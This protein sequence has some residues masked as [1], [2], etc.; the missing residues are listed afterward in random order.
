VSIRPTGSVVAAVEVGDVGHVPHVYVPPPWTDESIALSDTV[1]RHLRKVMRLDDGSPI[2]YTD[3]R[4]RIGSGTF[5]GEEVTRGAEDIVASVRPSIVLAVAP[6]QATDRAR[7]VVEKAAEL[8]VSELRWLT[9]RFSGPRFPRREKAEAW[10]IGAL[11]QSRGAHLMRIGT[12]LDVAEYQTLGVDLALVADAAAPGIL[13]AVAHLDPETVAIAIGPEG[14]FG[15]GE[16][17]DGLLHVGL[18]D[19][20]LRVET[21]A[22]VAV[23]ALRIR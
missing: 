10:A 20:V 1:R 11:E 5:A 22:I 16:V 9:T 21:A 14:G 19:R 4:G 13:G 7:F 15:A 6:P 17:P 12:P 3:G 8:A 23:G 18:G 2:S